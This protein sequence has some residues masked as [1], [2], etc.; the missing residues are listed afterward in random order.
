M[1][2]QSILLKIKMPL[3]KTSAIILKIATGKEGT[4]LR[5]YLFPSSPCRISF[6]YIPKSLNRLESNNLRRRNI[7]LNNFKFFDHRGMNMAWQYLHKPAK[8][9]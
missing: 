9:G 8:E 5:M 7:N 6:I 1:E 3:S 2:E 4:I